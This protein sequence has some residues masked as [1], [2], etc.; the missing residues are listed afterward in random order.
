[1]FMRPGMGGAGRLPCYYYLRPPIRSYRQSIWILS[2]MVRFKST[3]TGAL[4]C[5]VFSFS[6]ALEIDRFG[7]RCC[8]GANHTLD[9]EFE[10]VF[11]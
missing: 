3:Y 10:R 2:V 7:N 6:E 1:M 8:A 4:T 5:K 11:V 9:S